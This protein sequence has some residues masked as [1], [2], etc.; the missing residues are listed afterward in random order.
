[1]HIARPFTRVA[2]WTRPSDTTQYSAGDSVSD[3]ATTATAATFAL[4]SMGAMSGMGGVIHS[5]TL[6]KTDQDAT[7]ADFDIYF[8]SGP[9]VGSGFEDNA[10]IAITDAEWQTCIGF[11]SLTAT[12]N[13][14]S[15]V[16]GDLYCKSNLDLPYQCG[17]DTATVVAPLYF[18]VVARG[19]YTPASGEV[20]TL[21]VGAV[22]E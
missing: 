15:V 18:V 20:F 22:I 7:G 12:S 16:T 13:A 4:H 14:V 9:V 11:V 1:M 6:H 2:Q 10:A 17:A 21:T 5:V 8:F 3:N 19:T